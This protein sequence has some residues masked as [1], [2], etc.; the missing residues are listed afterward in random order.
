MCTMQPTSSSSRLS[1]TLRIC[2]ICCFQVLR[3]VSIGGQNLLFAGQ[4]MGLSF[5]TAGRSATWWMMM[6]FIQQLRTPIFIDVLSR[7]VGSEVIAPRISVN[8]SLAM[9]FR[10]YLDRP[11]DGEIFRRWIALHFSVGRQQPIPADFPSFPPLPPPPCCFDNCCI[12]EFINRVVVYGQN[13]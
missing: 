9:A 8:G 6:Q 4:S 11:G 12:F 10:F 3:I 5:F 13:K 7:L 2:A 1:K